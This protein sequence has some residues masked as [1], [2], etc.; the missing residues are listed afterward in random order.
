MV[1][2]ECYRWMT[3]KTKELA[4]K[5]SEGRLAC[6]HEGG[7]CPAYVPFCTHAIVEELSGIETD[8]EDPFIYAMEGTGYRKLL[9]HQRK[10]VDEVKTHL[11]ITEFK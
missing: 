4:N 3:K 7:Y 11:I 2:A 1:S 8:V 10:Q 6:I 9:H 5:Y